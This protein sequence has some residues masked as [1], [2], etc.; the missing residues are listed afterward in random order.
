MEVI[1]SGPQTAYN[2]DQ[3]DFKSP[4]IQLQTSAK[5]AIDSRN[6]TAKPSVSFA[7]PLKSKVWK[8][9]PI[10]MSTVLQVVN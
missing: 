4:A 6:P 7:W 5:D 10:F 2:N 3:D 8:T 1:N 9:C